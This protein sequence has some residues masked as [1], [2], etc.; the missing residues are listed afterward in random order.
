M[1]GTRSK[2]LP[3]SI[4]FSPPLTITGADTALAIFAHGLGGVET[5]TL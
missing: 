1:L 5:R 3:D 4:R 2:Y